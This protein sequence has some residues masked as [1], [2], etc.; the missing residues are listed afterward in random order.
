[1]D[2]KKAHVRLIWIVA[3]ILFGLVLLYCFV[4]LPL[5]IRM[6]SDVLFESSV[7]PAVF[8][9]VYTLVEYAVM[10]LAV[11]LVLF[12]LWERGLPYAWIPVAVY[13]GA[14]VLKFTLNTLQD[15]IV[16]GIPTSSALWED[17]G[18]TLRNISVEVGQF[19]VAFAILY[20]FFKKRRDALL[21]SHRAK[22]RLGQTDGPL[23]EEVYPFRKVFDPKNPLMLSSLIFTIVLTVFRIA[24]RLIYDLSGVG[25]LVA[26][27]SWGQVILYYFLDL[28]LGMA[29]YMCLV[30]LIRAWFSLKDRLTRSGED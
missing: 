8:E 9:I 18:I 16:D 6:V 10:W 20:P 17:L 26:D 2:E 24:F 14:I 29:G 19:A 25:N 3:L 27:F 22:V 4:L 23:R 7:I 28:M 21:D 15:W 1:M 30:L 13:I 5:Y 11:S 12:F